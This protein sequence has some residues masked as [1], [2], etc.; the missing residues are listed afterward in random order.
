MISNSI[1][2]P[3]TITLL[4]PPPKKMYPRECNTRGVLA[5]KGSHM[6]KKQTSLAL[7]QSYS[8][9]LPGCPK[10]K[11]LPISL[12]QFPESSWTTDW[13]PLSL[14]HRAMSSSKNPSKKLGKN[15]RLPFCT[16]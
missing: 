13:H 5:G 11:P 7:V 6:A 1:I 14:A 15:T 4:H 2:M 16:H 12:F 8:V 10:Q 3:K 9:H